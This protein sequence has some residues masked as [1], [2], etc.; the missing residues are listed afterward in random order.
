MGFIMALYTY[1]CIVPPS[2]FSGPPLSCSVVLLYSLFLLFYHM[3]A[4]ILC[5]RISVA[6][7][8]H[9][10]QRHSGRK[11]L[12]CLH[13]WG[14]V[15]WVKPMPELKLGRNLEARADWETVKKWCFLIQL[16]TTSQMYLQLIGTPPLQSLIKKML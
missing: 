9:H 5:L 16:R 2:S 1:S 11:C 15:Y 12:F 7:M 3:S 10:D 4:I 6:G 8:K 13:I 14:T